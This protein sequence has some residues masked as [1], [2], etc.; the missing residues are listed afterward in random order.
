MVRIRL[1][2][3][4]SK[5]RPSYKVVVADSRKPR[6]GRF[7]EYIGYS[8]IQP[9]GRPAL[10]SV[11]MER[12]NYWCSVGAQ[13]SHSV[14]KLVRT[15]SGGNGN[16][17]PQAPAP[18]PEKETEPAP[19]AA[20]PAVPAPSETPPAPATGMPPEQK[21]EADAPADQPAAEQQAPPSEG[22]K[23]A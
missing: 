16:A 2:R 15:L 14:R 7:I 4:G 21:G 6:N 19:A 12:Y 5:K 23:T 3:G 13:P 10:S 1:A 11:N 9:G 17:E 8:K 22:G 18:A 20:D